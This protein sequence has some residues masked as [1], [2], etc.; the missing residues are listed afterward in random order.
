MSQY[1]EHEYKNISRLFDDIETLYTRTSDNDATRLF[2]VPVTG[3]CK[4]V[5]DIFNQCYPEQ[6]L[7]IVPKHYSRLCLPDYDKQ[8]LILCFSGGKD[9]VAAALHYKKRYNVYLYHMQG[10]NKVYAHENETAER[11]ADM[12]NLPIFIDKVSL[13]GNHQFVEHFMKN[14]LIA[15]GALHYGIYNDITTKV[16]FGNYYTSYLADNAFDVCAGDCVE[17]W[18]AYEQAIR[19]IITKFRIYVPLKNIATSYKVLLKN[20]H[21]LPEIVSCVG[22][23][24]YR[25]YWKQEVEKKYDIQLM[26]NRCGRCWKCCAEY[27]YFTDHDVLTFNE[28]YYKYCLE[29][30]L[31]TQH[32]EYGW[33]SCNIYHLWNSYLF[34]PISKSKL[35]GIRNAV[36]RNR[37][38]KYTERDIS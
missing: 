24:R 9:S 11:L 33:S 17:M 38:I 12:L 16:A 4:S 7:T 14:I 3:A 29:Q 35:K 1:I 37:K 20:P 10:I 28:E 18:R 26:P 27:I 31:K 15:N 25:A 6:A 8:N 34:Y 22:P 30:L 2:S 13:K 36:I 32:K 23:Y 21:L 5:V 19:N